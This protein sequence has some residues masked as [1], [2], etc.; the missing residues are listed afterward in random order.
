MTPTTHESIA[1]G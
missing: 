1:D